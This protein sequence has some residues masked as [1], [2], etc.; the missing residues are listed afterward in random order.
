MIHWRRG[1]A[2]L[3]LLG[4]G[5]LCVL[6]AVAW[7]QYRQVALLSSHV[8]H[9][10]DNL[11]WSF[12]QLESEA[13]QLRDLLR[14]Q[15]RYPEGDQRDAVRLRYELF[16][17]RL[18]LVDPRRTQSIAELGTDHGPTFARLK[19]LVDRFDGVFSQAETGPLPPAKS[20][21]LLQALEALHE[22]MHDLSMHA[23]QV[24]ADQVGQRNDTVRDQS[25]LSVG[26]TAFQ[27]LLA[28]AFAAITAR[29]FRSLQRRRH[30]QERLAQQFQQ[31]RLDA[32]RANQGKTQFLANMS[33]EL[34]TPL[35]GMLGNLWL[36]QRSALDQ[37][38]ADQ[39]RTAH[40][41]ATHLLALLNDIL[42]ISRLESG[43]VDI[44]NEALSLRQLLDKVRAPMALD[45]Q[46]KGLRLDVTM[47]DGLPE[48]V[49][50]DAQRLR[51]I[52]FNLMSNALKFCEQG[53]VG[54]QLRRDPQFTPRPG[55]VGLC[56]VVRDS[57][58]GIDPATMALLFER[59]TQ[60]DNSTARRYGGSGL[61]LEISRNLARL[62]GG[63]IE[64]ASSAGQG[65]EFTLRLSLAVT[66]APADDDEGA[67]ELARADAAWVSARLPSLDL[68]VVDDN[69]TNRK[70]M[71]SLL[72]RMGHRVRLAEDGAQAVAAV[73]QQTPDLVLMDLHMPVQ[74]GEQATRALRALPAPANALP[75]V[76]LTADAFA[77]T[78]D[79]V[80][81][82]GMNGFLSKPVQVDELERLLVGLFGKNQRPVTTTPAMALT[83]APAL[84]EA[85]PPATPAAPPAAAC[86][87]PR[88]GDLARLLDMSA[89]GQLCLGV[90]VDGCRQ[91]LQGFFDDSMGARTRLFTLLDQGQTHSVEAQAH[92]LR[93]AAANLGLRA[94]QQCAQQLEQQAQ[95]GS[96]DGA[97]CGA[98]AQALR[99]ALAGSRVLLQRMGLLGK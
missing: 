48:W 79:R 67:V 46:A 87:R 84:P 71:A 68:L 73:Q 13:M 75:V 72:A 66:T 18:P 78:R 52:L 6:A 98:H 94:L 99:E 62:M 24:V 51:Q 2:L 25:Q 80:L 19:A 21:A 40:D 4:S 53:Q 81:A 63:D 95:A 86:P 20:A 55:W 8:R 92:G 83:A 88:A 90:G 47:D 35:N 89:L 65:A 64:V 36:L 61:G 69:A 58:I 85:G 44:V 41:S 1:S 7:V 74:D 70:F 23:N 37:Q 15:L 16:A 82:A 43:R 56:F 9:E 30:E 96:L 17:S 22:P 29:Q 12:V 49:L 97:G 28:L 50:A 5:L 14:D 93:G 32:E 11:V 54:L 33:H 77:Q 39:L 10:G 34:R 27:S 91:L 38:Q 3:V 59:F 26:L 42:D 57:G 76:A 31:A 60:G 45:A